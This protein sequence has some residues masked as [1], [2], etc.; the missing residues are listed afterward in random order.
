MKPNNQSIVIIDDN[1]DICNAL[2]SLFTSVHFNVKTYTSAQ[3]FL[4]DG[5]KNKNGCLIIDVRMPIMSGLELLEQLNLQKNRVPVIMITGYGDIPMAIRAMKL[6]AV[7]FVLKPFNDQCLLETVQKYIDRSVCT[8]TFE[9]INQRISNL[10]ERERQ[11]IDLIL[12]GKLS[13]EIAYKLS[14]SMSTVEAH[15]ANIMRKMQ[16]KNLAQLI[17]FCLQSQFNNEFS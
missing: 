5:H 13:K 9:Q 12:E 14:I 11:V 3:L 6:G 1:S 8:N 17:K 16:A 2:A 15:R 4:D 7:D 10:S